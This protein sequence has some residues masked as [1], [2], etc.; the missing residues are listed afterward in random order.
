MITNNAM[1]GP[2]WPDYNTS[3][4]YNASRHIADDINSH[5]SSFTAA[6][7]VGAGQSY[8]MMLHVEHM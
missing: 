6:S 5:A 3:R 1:L 4:H 7:R 2:S 8:L